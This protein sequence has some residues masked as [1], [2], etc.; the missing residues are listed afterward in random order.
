MATTINKLDDINGQE[1]LLWVDVETTGLDIKNGEI[2]E[3]GFAITDT[4]GITLYEQ[5]AVID[6]DRI[7]VGYNNLRALDMH[8]Y[9]G[10]L[11][12]SLKHHNIDEMTDH[13]HNAG[14]EE[15]GTLEQEINE[16]DNILTQL[17]HNHNLIHLAGRNPQFDI[18]WL[19][20]KTNWARI[21]KHYDHRRFDM[22]AINLFANYADIN[23][24][25]ATEE[26]QNIH[27]TYACIYY[28]IIHYQK[29]R[30]QIKKLKTNEPEQP[31]AVPSPSPSPSPSA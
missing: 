12:L 28:D 16:L 25:P 29:I 4:D 27:R 26:I 15:T 2:L 31:T 24:Q 18:A 21:A 8:S 30:A 17:E 23:D 20:A 22:G 13:K 14:H 19:T 11:E 1:L 7:N 9:N 5:Y 3:T 10:L 6:H